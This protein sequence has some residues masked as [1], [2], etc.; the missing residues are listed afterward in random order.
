[1]L[2]LVGFGALL[3]RRGERADALTAVAVTLLTL[4]AICS[5][6][7][8]RGGWTIGPRYLVTVIPFLAWGALE[9]LEIV[10][11]RFP[12]LA[13]TAALACTTVAL[14]ASGAPS[15]YYPHLPPE[16]GRPLPE[17]LAVLIAHD[18]APY[19]AG[20]LLDLYGTPSMWP[21]FATAA[22]ALAL[23]FVRVG[24]AVA[25]KRVL[26]GALLLGAALLWPLC[27]GASEGPRVR[28]AVAFIT[29]NWSPAG[30][31]RAARLRTE[32]GRR[33]NVDPDLRRELAD[34]YLQEGRDREARELPQP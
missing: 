12:A 9:G 24:P 3:L 19:N 14:A 17:L 33:E 27:S 18:Y 8:W 10:A 26:P 11:R 2:A 7:N 6:N 29:R 16:L 34:T 4:L 32:L 15:A 1:V 31:D 30:H 5:M 21:L 25:K 23:V 13:F 22:A 28:G 20:S